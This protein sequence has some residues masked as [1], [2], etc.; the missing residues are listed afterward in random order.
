MNQLNQLT[1][2]GYSVLDVI[3]SFKNACDKKI[4]FEFKNRKKVMLIK[5]MLIQLK[6]KIFQVG[7]QNLILQTCV[8]IHGFG[9]K[10]ILRVLTKN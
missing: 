5:I 1:G 4:K 7:K 2:L 6:L 9:K 10:I 8:W 3:K